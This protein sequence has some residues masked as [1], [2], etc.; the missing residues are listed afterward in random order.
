MR[1]IGESSP[2]CQLQPGEVLD[3][4]FEAIDEYMLSREQE[5]I[6]TASQHEQEEITAH[7]EQ[8]TDFR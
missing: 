1:H 8:R 2:E 6:V 4:P 7:V 5:V 3:K